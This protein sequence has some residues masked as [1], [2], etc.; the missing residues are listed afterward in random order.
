VQRDIVKEDCST[1]AK[2]DPF[3]EQSN[4]DGPRRDVASA[5]SSDSPEAGKE[6][7]ISGYPQLEVASD[8]VVTASLYWA[9]CQAVAKLQTP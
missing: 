3:A 1:A 8:A 4:E 9:H 6:S 5:E 7:P 2:A